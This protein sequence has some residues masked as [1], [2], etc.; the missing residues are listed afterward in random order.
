MACGPIDRM[1]EEP[2][3]SVDRITLEGGVSIALLD[4]SVGPSVA[5][6]CRVACWIR[7]LRRLQGN[8][9]E[10]LPEVRVRQR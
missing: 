2:W 5:M 4:G 9:G 8:G 10:G 7:R 3:L 1:R 6:G